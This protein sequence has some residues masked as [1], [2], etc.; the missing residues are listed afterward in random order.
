MAACPY[1]SAGAL[2]SESLAMKSYHVV[3]YWEG[4][5]RGHVL[6]SAKL[7]QQERDHDLVRAL[8]RISESSVPDQPASLDIDEYVWIM[9]HVA[10]LRRIAID[11]LREY[12]TMK[13]RGK[14]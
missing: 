9:R 1:C 3:E 6:C 7:P 10:T 14:A 13:S 12:E 4:N 11:A 8:E 5:E 2:F